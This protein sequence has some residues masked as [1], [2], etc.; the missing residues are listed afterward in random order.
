[1]DQLFQKMHEKISRPTSAETSPR[2]S[3]GIS[4]D[5]SPRFHMQTEDRHYSLQDI[6]D[7]ERLSFEKHS[8]FSPKV[9]LTK[10]SDEM[11][12]PRRYREWELNRKQSFGGRNFTFNRDHLSY[13]NLKF[14][15]EKKSQSDGQLSMTR[16]PLFKTP[17]MID[18]ESRSVPNSPMVSA[19]L[20]EKLMLVRMH[21]YSKSPIPSKPGSPRSQQDL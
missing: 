10:M 6:I 3:P 16:I 20:E 4:R 2:I 17:E 19:R 14:E 5:V 15:N 12:L 8:K 7:I 13:I 11:V 21:E 9:I 18:Y 1:M